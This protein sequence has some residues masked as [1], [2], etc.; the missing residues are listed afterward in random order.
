MEHPHRRGDL[1]EGRGARLE[2]GVGR[3]DLLD[4]RPDEVAQLDELTWGGVLAVEL[5]PL[6]DPVHVGGAEQAGLPARGG[7]GGG[8]HRGRRALALGAGDVDDLA[9]QVGVAEPTEDPPHAAEAEV[10]AAAG[11]RD[12]LEID[13]AVEC[14]QPVLVVVGH[15]M[16]RYR[17]VGS[18]GIRP[19]IPRQTCRTSAGRRRAGARPRSVGR[20]GPG[21]RPGGAP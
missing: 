21:A 2:M 10:G 16:A 3:L 20:G 7:Q 9:G 13:P 19:A 14:V 5:E 4:R 12:P 6:L 1:E 11:H 15:A 8:D 18:G 17:Y